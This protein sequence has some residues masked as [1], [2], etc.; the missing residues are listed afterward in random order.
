MKTNLYVLA[1]ALFGLAAPGQGATLHATTDM[2]ELGN[3]TIDFTDA[4]LDGLLEYD[5]IDAFS[6]FLSLSA[7]NFLVNTVPDIAGISIFSFPADF[8]QTAENWRFNN[9]NPGITT[10]PRDL[11]TYELALDRPDGPVGQDTPPSVPLPAGLP[12]LAGALGLL[13]LRRR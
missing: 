6:G 2:A 9:T 7:D 12:L 1:A 8:G 11:W 10:A 3:F 4:N 13:A 5:E